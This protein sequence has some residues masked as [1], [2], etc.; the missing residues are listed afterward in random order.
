MGEQFGVL[1]VHNAPDIM[2]LHE[3]FLKDSG[4]EKRYGLLAAMAG[5]L[6]PNFPAHILAEIEAAAKEAGKDVSLLLFANTVADL[7]SGMG[8]STVIIEKTRSTTGG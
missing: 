4:Q 6:K 5:L 7:S 8:C 1:A 3:R 2:G